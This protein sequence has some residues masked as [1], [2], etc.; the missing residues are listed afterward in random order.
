MLG[1]TGLLNSGLSGAG[2][3]V[4]AGYT[5][6]PSD[7]VKSVSRT[8]GDGSTVRVMTVSFGTPPKPASANRF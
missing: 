3:G 8:P 2:A 4:Q 6:Y 7:L 1:D 5:S